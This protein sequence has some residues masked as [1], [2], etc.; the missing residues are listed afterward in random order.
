MQIPYKIK[1]KREQKSREIESERE[2]ETFNFL[3]FIAEIMDLKEILAS[4][5]AEAF[6]F[7]QLSSP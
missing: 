2:N 6:R 4:R 5:E 7:H 3:D 1:G